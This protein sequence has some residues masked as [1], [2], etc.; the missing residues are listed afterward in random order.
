MKSNVDKTES[1]YFNLS[2]HYYVILPYKVKGTHKTYKRIT[3]FLEEDEKETNQIS[4]CLQLLN[5]TFCHSWLIS[6]NEMK[7]IS[8]AFFVA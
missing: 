6:S 3:L 5:F 2:F 1:D 4:T 8:L 7:R